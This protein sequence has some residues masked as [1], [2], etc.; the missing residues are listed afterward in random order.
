MKTAEVIS[1]HFK[2]KGFASWPKGLDSAG[3]A[4]AVCSVLKQNG[5][6]I[7]QSII[8]KNFK[9]NRVNDCYHSVVKFSS[10]LGFNA[11]VHEL[12][13]IADLNSFYIPCVA[14]QREKFVVIKSVSHNRVK[15]DGSEAGS[16]W[17][18]HKEF[19]SRN[20]NKILYISNITAIKNSE[21]DTET[22]FTLMDL[23]H[24]IQGL[25]QSVLT[26]FL[27]STFLLF[28]AFIIPLFTQLAIDKIIPNY[29]KSLLL[30][31]CVGFF[32]ILSIDSV[33]KVLREFYVTSVL[34]RLNANTLA[35]VFE[36]LIHLPMAFFEGRQLGDI[37]SRFKSVEPLNEKV[38]KNLVDIV[39]DSLMVITMASVMII[40]APAIAA[41]SLATFALVSIIRFSFNGSIKDLEREACEHYADSSS[42]FIETFSSMQTIRMLQNE[43]ER[44][45]TWLERHLKA[46]S[47][48]EKRQK[49]IIVVDVAAGFLNGIEMIIAVALAAAS[50]IDSEMTLGAMFAYLSYRV[51]FAS[52]AANL[53]KSIFDLRLLAI[54]LKR[55]SVIF[56]GNRIQYTNNTQGPR[57]ERSNSPSIEFRNVCF[58]HPGSNKEIVHNLSLK[59]QPGE[60]VVIAGPSG[61]GKS[62]LLKLMMGLL[63][64]TSGRVLING[65]TLYPFSRR[66]DGTCA[67]VLQGDRIFDE[68]ILDNI[69][70]NS[71]DFDFE[72]IIEC[73][74][75]ANIHSEIALMDKAYDTQLNRN[76]MN[77]S[78]GQEQRILLARALYQ[79]PEIL[80]L[81]EI[82][83]NL[84]VENEE[85]MNKQIQGLSMT[86]IVIAH[87]GS[88]D[89]LADKIVRVSDLVNRDE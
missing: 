86:R 88:V 64:P 69:V 23:Y 74:K 28:F 15:L 63:S 25:K 9:R 85:Y 21:T 39:I 11:W 13:G 84:D 34:I 76:E 41:V 57:Q 14:K 42:S 33:T 65:R 2:R 59:I 53:V 36:Q 70:A 72:R 73:S 3:L 8:E 44:K 83:S 27:L 77:I 50:V 31:T 62:T 54:Y 40:Y 48:D 67:A 56:S 38:T 32:F 52:H 20:D 7:D 60:L 16:Y 19:D 12:S 4:G 18:T 82:T 22:D 75:L 5:K 58:S 47:L 80:F 6:Q 49:L 45:N 81:D 78:T 37:M 68:S 1:Q 30:I 87:K 71:P 24:G 61:G 43:N 66:R 10:L 29:D 17:V 46:L 79:Q 35:C 51:L 89:S 26:I 55:I